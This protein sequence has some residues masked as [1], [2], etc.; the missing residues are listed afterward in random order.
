M[1]V[2]VGWQV[3]PCSRAPTLMSAR[4]GPPDT[5]TIDRRRVDPP[6]GCRATTEPAT[7]AGRRSAERDQLKNNRRTTEYRTISPHWPLA[8]GDVERPRGVLASGAPDR[9]CRPP[10]PTGRRRSLGADAYSPLASSPLLDDAHR[11]HHRRPTGSC[12]ADR[13]TLM[14]PTCIAREPG[15]RTPNIC[16][17]QR[18]G[19]KHDEFRHVPPTHCRHVEH[20]TGPDHPGRPRA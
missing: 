4:N 1:P 3:A 17:K 16:I 5:E 14:Q 20:R 9:R 19:G 15:L 6:A 10:V 8:C 7:L 2:H 11:R 12:P 13:V 18:L